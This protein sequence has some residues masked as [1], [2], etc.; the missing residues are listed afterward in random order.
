MGAHLIQASRQR[1]LISLIA[2]PTGAQL[3][4]ALHRWAI[5]KNYRTDGRS[6]IIIAPMGN[7]LQLSLCRRAIITCH[8]T[9]GQSSIT[10]ALTGDHKISSR[11]RATTYIHRADGQSANIIT[12]TGNHQI[13]SR[14]RAPIKHRLALIH[15]AR[16]D[17]FR[18][19]SLPC[20]FMRPST[21]FLLPGVGNLS[22]RLS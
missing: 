13:S 12:L 15:R 16:A 10:I 1:G 8:H 20:A 2:V 22:Y 18:T 6:S 4:Q 17:R 3:N 5:F 9:D 21:V 11:R 19:S 14:Q 7:N